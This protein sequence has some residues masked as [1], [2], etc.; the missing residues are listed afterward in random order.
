[1]RAGELFWEGKMMSMNEKGSTWDSPGD[2]VYVGL[3]MMDGLG[4]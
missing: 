2:S 3:G 4:K 1:M